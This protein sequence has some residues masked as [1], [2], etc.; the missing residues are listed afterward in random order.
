MSG[1]ILSLTLSLII[2]MSAFTCVNA[3]SAVQNDGEI[4]LAEADLSKLI[5]ASSDVW[6]ETVTNTT[7]ISNDDS[8]WKF[9]F[10]KDEGA[11][12]SDFEI[13][14]GNYTYNFVEPK[15]GDDGKYDY[16]HVET[17]G[18]HT[19]VFVDSSSTTMPSTQGDILGKWWIRPAANAN[20]RVAKVF[21]VPRSGQITLS[22]IDE[23]GDANIYARALDGAK[24]GPV[25]YIMKENADGEYDELWKNEVVF[26]G[27]T[28]KK[29]L[30]TISFEDISLEAEAGEKIW[31]IVSAEQS[32]NIQ[33][34]YVYWNPVVTYSYVPETIFPE[35]RSAVSKDTEFSLAFPDELEALTKENISITA[36][37]GSP[38]VKTFV[39]DKN[40]VFM[41]FDGLKGE[42]AYTVT[43]SG[44]R[45]Q[46]SEEVHKYTFEFTTEYIFEYPVYNSLDAWPET[47]SSD[48]MKND[49]TL[50]QWLYRNTLTKD[51]VTPY[52]P[53]SLTAQNNTNIYVPPV[54]NDGEYDYTYVGEKGETS[55]VYCDSQDNAYMRNALGKYWSRLSVATGSEP[56]QDADNEIVKQFTA[57]ES[58][59]VSLTCYDM[60]KNPRIYNRKLTSDNPYGAV[61]KIIKK[62]SESDGEDTLLWKH[63]FKYTSQT[64]PECGVAVLDFENIETDVSKGEKIWFV[65]SG[66]L[67]QSSY[68][69]QVFWTPVVAYT[70]IIPT[71]VSCDPLN[72]AEDIVPNYVHRLTFDRSIE[73]PT[74]DDIEIS[75]GAA[76]KEVY[77]ENGNTLCIVYD[78]LSS[79]TKY[80]VRLKNINVEY[81]TE[82]N[83][84]I[85][86]YSFTTGS[87]VEFGD[88]EISGG[89]LKDGENTVSVFINNAEGSAKPYHAVLAVFICQGTLSEYEVISAKYVCRDDITENDSLSLN[90]DLEQ[91]EGCFVKA[92]LAESLPSAVS[93]LPVKIFD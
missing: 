33:M 62:A 10:S 2:L 87:F 92:V 21:T 67:G 28:D 8:V 41:T 5:F 93:L 29:Q 35:E 68:A 88:I 77:V 49:D 43:V 26:D 58:G 44:I 19:R 32:D 27:S 52:V 78:K 17:S 64:V 65:I 90:F 61:V 54:L 63:E 7:E 31:F 71:L 45:I 81:V 38:T 1:K 18:N 25:L 46:G 24:M 15:L 50:W 59:K 84:N 12:Y 89:V 51:T 75:G 85:Y 36:E 74:A 34:K 37:S 80:D 82:P 9:K 70:Q 83:E 91:K 55:R 4:Y 23:S 39:H 30:K 66:E 56:K 40:T 13:T 48:A 6:P 47:L 79:Y 86:E 57:P 73:L 72:N 14:R 16:T 42:T 20:R 53:Y 3:D 69:K 60:N 76:V 22:A 11:S